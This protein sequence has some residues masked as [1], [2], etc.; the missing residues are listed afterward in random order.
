MTTK[1]PM[2]SPIWMM[3]TTATMISMMTT[4]LMTGMTTKAM[5]HPQPS[6]TVN[7]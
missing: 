3:T 5:S 4:T 1:N 6:L 7:S 2:L